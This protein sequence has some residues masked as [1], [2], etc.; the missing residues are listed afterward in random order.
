MNELFYKSVRKDGSSIW[1]YPGRGGEVYEIG[2]RYCFPKDRPAYGFRPAAWSPYYTTRPVEGLYAVWET[3]PEPIPAH[4][5]LICL[6]EFSQSRVR[7]A[8]W[9]E[10]WMGV[11]KAPASFE[12]VAWTSCCFQVV[13]EIFVPESWRPY[14]KL[15]RRERI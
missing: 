7:L 10:L 2:K 1:A 11:D 8:Y 3:R 15:E 12:T 4:R 6:G 9:D 13:G 14:K 5:V